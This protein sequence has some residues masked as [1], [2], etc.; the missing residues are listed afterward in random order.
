MNFRNRM[1]FDKWMDGKSDRDLLEFIAQQAND[2]ALRIDLVSAKVES[3]GLRLTQLEGNYTSLSQL[4]QS[5]KDETRKAGVLGGGIIGGIIAGIVG[6]I[7][8]IGKFLH[9][10]E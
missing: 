8:A 2:N 6:T 9:W 4:I 5:Q 7:F 3:H 1:E 10:W